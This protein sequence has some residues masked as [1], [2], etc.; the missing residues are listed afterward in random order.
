MN[1]PAVFSQQIVNSTNATCTD[2]VEFYNPN[3]NGGTDFF[4]FGLTAD[5]T[6]TGTSGCVVASTVEGAPFTTTNVNGGP[7][8]IIVDNYSTAV[9]AA[10]IYLSAE[11]SSTAYKFTQNGLQ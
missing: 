4:F 9:Q 1:T 7:S 2:W 11:G 10:S 5:C 8:G 3:V 6:G